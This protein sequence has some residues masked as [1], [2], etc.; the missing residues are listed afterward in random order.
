MPAHRSND[1]PLARNADIPTARHVAPDRPIA[2]SHFPPT[3]RYACPP[4]PKPKPSIHFPFLVLV[5]V[6][7]SQWRLRLCG[8]KIFSAHFGSLLC[9]HCGEAL[10]TLRSPL[11][12][13][14]SQIASNLDI[15]STANDPSVA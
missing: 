10:F 14:H 5:A 4:D 8:E 9:D 7:L 2:R 12:T 1:A 3:P 11:A 13:R 6:H 15:P